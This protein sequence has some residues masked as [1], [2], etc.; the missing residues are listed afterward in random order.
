MHITTSQMRAF[1]C[2]W[3]R[4]EAVIKATGEGLTADLKSFDVSIDCD[5][6]AMVTNKSGETGNSGDWFLHDLD[7]GDQYVGAIAL[8]CATGVEL[9]DH[10][11]VRW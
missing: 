7:F 4:K 1:Y 11:N 5:Q 6:P 8:E 10:G 2:C 3:T 9:R